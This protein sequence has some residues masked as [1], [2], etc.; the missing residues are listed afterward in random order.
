M[1]S[2][3][4][5]VS[6]PEIVLTQ[7]VEDV[8]KEQVPATSTPYHLVP[9]ATP[10]ESLVELEALAFENNPTLRRLRHEAAAEFA[11]VGYIGKLPDPSVRGM[12]FTP[13]MQFEPDRQRAELQAMQ[14]IPWLGRLRAEERQVCMEAMAAENLYRAERLKVLGEL[15]SNWFQL[16]IIGKQIET[17]EAEKAQLESLVKTAN[18]RVA[19]GDAQPGDVLMATLELSSLQEQALTYAREFAAPS[20]E[21]NRL[22]GRNIAI[23]IPAPAVIDLEVPDWN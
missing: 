10:T 16:Y 11:R 6:P 5:T 12:V 14:M 8:V 21:I 22:I 4:Q 20:A 3:R 17:T 1:S 7:H 23:P 13:P 19:T 2:I 15:R 9:A 18:A